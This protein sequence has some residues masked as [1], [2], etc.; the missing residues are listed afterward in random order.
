MLIQPR[1]NMVEISSLNSKRLYKITLTQ[2]SVRGN[3]HHYTQIEEFYTNKDKLQMQGILQVFR[4]YFL[5]LNVDG[6]LLCIFISIYVLLF[7]KYSIIF[8]KT[9]FCCLFSEL[10]VPYS[11]I[12]YL[13]K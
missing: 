9:I 4:W 3:H 1:G 6:L 5:G 8:A 7:Y 12:V 10:I 13:E 11:R 2:N